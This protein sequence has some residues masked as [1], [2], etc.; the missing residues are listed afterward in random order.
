MGA[1]GGE[2][3]VI[4]IRR[5]SRLEGQLR[6]IALDN[7]FGRMSDEVYL[8]RKSELTGQIEA[9]RRPE[10]AAQTVDPKRALGY[11]DDLRSLW[12]AELPESPE[13]EVIRHEYELRRAQ[14]TAAGF[15]RLQ[16]LGPVIVEAKLSEEPMAGASLALSLQP[17]RA[18]LVGDRADVVRR[19]LDG[20]RSRLAHADTLEARKK[21]RQRAG[22][23]TLSCFGR[24]E[25]GSPA[26]NDLPIVMRLAEPPEP[27]ELV[28]SA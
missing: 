27:V 18:E 19:L 4:D 6:A 17:E 13:H 9:A 2:P 8:R 14:A 25:R 24:G 3:P 22:N 23:G 15:E 7:A 5:V 1:L 20:R 28:R 26:T 16:V 12:D 10:S 11:L 21:R